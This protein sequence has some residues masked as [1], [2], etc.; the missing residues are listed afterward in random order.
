VKIRFL[1]LPAGEKESEEPWAELAEEG[2]VL[3]MEGIRFLVRDGRFI[4]VTAPLE[5]EERDVRLWLLGSVAAALLHQRGYLPIH[6]NIVALP[7]AGAA[8][9]AGNSGAGKSTL[10]AWMEAHGHEVLADDLCAIRTGGDRP[11]LFEG[12]PRV[13]LNVDSLGLLGRTPEGL[14]KVAWD[15]EKYHVPLGRAPRQGSLEPLELRR[16]Y[17]LDRTAE[18]QAFRI[19][20][21]TGMVAAS[22][23]LANAFRWGLGQL[24]HGG[25]R[26]QF[27]QCVEVARH[28]AVFRICR[29]WDMERLDE[30]AKAIE[31]HLMTPLEELRA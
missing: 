19:E 14:E 11:V 25:K 29:T 13:K 10:A 4:E 15:L 1:R 20:Q 8:A 17:L 23:V 22:G 6:A 2:V 18:A 5:T 24:I 28:S 26:A 30:E 16:I 31:R 21:V 3:R 27:D 12:I 7:G 9:F